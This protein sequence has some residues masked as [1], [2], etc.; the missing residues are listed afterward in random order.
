MCVLII[1]PKFRDE[2]L[3][4]FDTTVCM[5]VVYKGCLLSM[6]SMQCMGNVV[7]KASN[8]DDVTIYGAV[9]LGRRFVGLKPVQALETTFLQH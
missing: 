4:F 5:K 2:F 3:S 7:S 9:C 1:F 6:R 8:V